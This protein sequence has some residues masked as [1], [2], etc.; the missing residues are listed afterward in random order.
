MLFGNPFM[1]SLATDPTT[2]KF[3]FTTFMNNQF[4][5]ERQPVNNVYTKFIIFNTELHSK[6][7]KTPDRW[8]NIYSATFCRKNT[9]ATFHVFRSC[10]TSKNCRTL[11]YVVPEVLPPRKFPR[12]PN[13]HNLWQEI[14]NCKSILWFKSYWLVGT[15]RH[16]PWFH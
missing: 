3:L 11:Y 2:L 5:C 6:F 10:T 1:V 9:L 4:V 13:W 14:I 16:I 15:V 7:D 12:L 8:L